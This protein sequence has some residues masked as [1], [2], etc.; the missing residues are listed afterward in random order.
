MTWHDSGMETSPAQTPEDGPREAAIAELDRLTAA[1]TKAEERLASA[2]ENLQEAIARH[3]G[4]K[5]LRPGETAVHTPWDRNYVAK[6]ARE[7]GVPPLR[8]ATVTSRRKSG[9][10]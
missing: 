2:R 3:L 4:S 8:E 5:T 10:S 7:R 9:E 6:V 1:Y